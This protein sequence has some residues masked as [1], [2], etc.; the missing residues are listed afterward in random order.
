MTYRSKRGTPFISKCWIAARTVWRAPG[1][2]TTCASAPRASKPVGRCGPS[3]PPARRSPTDTSVPPAATLQ[4]PPIAPADTRP[5]TPRSA[6]EALP[7]TRTLAAAPFMGCER[8]STFT[9]PPCASDPYSTDAG[10]RI[11]SMRSIV[12][13]SMV[14][15]YCPGPSR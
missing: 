6:E 15:R 7:A 5:R 2:Y 11:T 9:T 8:V 13:G 14:A 4:W 1:W 10:P 3:P 12:S